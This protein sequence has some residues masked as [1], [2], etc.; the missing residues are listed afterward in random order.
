MFGEGADLI[1][2]IGD[3]LSGGPPASILVPRKRGEVRSDERLAAH[4]A[5]ERRL[6]DRVRSAAGPDE[7][8]AIF[9]T[10][11]DE[12]FREVPDHP[13]LLARAAG[14]LERERDIEWDIAQ[15]E[16]YLTPG[17]TFLEVGAG[18][19]ALSRRVAGCAARVY[20][21]EIC[22]QARAPLPANVSLV[23]SDGRSID[24]PEASVD[25]AFSDQLMEHL[26]P[27]DAAAQLANIHRA[28]KPGGA[29]VCITP[30]RL[31]GPSDISAYFDDEAHGFHLREYSLR[32]ITAILRES[33]FPR[34]RA[35]V[36]ARGFFVRFPRLLLQALEAALEWLPAGL[37]RRV[38]GT[39]PMRALLGLRVAAIK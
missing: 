30:N 27:D 20:A 33:G 26:H 4:Y 17:C 35:Y 16:P 34:V 7:R 5:V 14:A 15:L 9:A 29:Y 25:L 18:D 10:M 3:L 32:E 23:I 8:R 21:V 2:L 38:A 19:C 12:L 37:R 11:Y 6:A 13:R 36:G 22:D 31:Y 24:V 28:L 1:P 39:K